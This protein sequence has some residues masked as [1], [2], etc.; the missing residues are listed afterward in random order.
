MTG[1]AMEKAKMVELL[2]KMLEIRFFEEKVNDLFA[3]NLIY[4]TSHLYVGQEAVAVGACSVLEPGDLVT[5]THRGHGHAIAKGVSLHSLMAELWGKSTGLGRGKGGTQHLSDL[6]V[7][8]LGTN[9]ITAGFIPIATG[10]ALACKM[11]KSAQIVLCFF[12]D[13]ATNQGVFH[14]SLNMASL[15]KLPIVYVCENNLYA[16]STHVRNSTAVKDLYLRAS[17]YAMSAEPVDGMDVLAVRS[18]VISAVKHA[19]AGHGPTFIECKTYRFL[20]HS[21]SDQRVYRTREEEEEWKKR[22][23]ILLFSRML[24]EKGIVREEDIEDLREAVRCVVEEAVQFASSSP[25]PGP[26]ELEKG[27]YSA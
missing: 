1:Q 27:V 14:E 10:A 17:A 6:S 22:D 12:G 25:Y 23:P 4:G 26:S 11:R 8:F 7:G 18:S 19:R 21:K 24:V 3:R 9:G 2:R 16:M 15:W 5:S 20:G 13:G